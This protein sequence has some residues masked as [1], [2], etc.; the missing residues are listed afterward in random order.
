MS[1][2]GE[3]LLVARRAQGLTQEDVCRQL[4]ITQAALSRYENDQR[5]PDGETLDRFAQIY[6]VT[7]NFLHHG[8]RMQGALSLI[9]ICGDRKPRKPRSGG[10]S[11]PV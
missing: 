11:R 5:L 8:H 1:G 6:G 9:R 7:V 4:G 3:A 2:P 10:G